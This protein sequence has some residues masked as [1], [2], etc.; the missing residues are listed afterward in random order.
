MTLSRLLPVLNVDQIVASVGNRL[1]EQIGNVI[2][3]F[4][5]RQIHATQLWIH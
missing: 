2:P 1:F 4:N 3:S 5:V